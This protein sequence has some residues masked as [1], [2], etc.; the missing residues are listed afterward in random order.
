MGS[1]CTTTFH[2]V[3]SD[4]LVSVSGTSM[5]PVCGLPVGVPTPAMTTSSRITRGGNGFAF[6]RERSLDLLGQIGRELFDQSLSRADGESDCCACS[7]GESFQS[8]VAV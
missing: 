8:L 5:T 1:L 7:L 6:H 3:S 4:S 2:G